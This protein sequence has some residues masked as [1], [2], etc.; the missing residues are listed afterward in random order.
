MAGLKD[1]GSRKTAR[2]QLWLSVSGVHLAWIQT[3]PYLYFDPESCTAAHRQNQ[4]GGGVAIDTGFPSARN[5]GRVPEPVAE[6]AARSGTQVHFMI[7]TTSMRSL[8]VR[9]M[10]HWDTGVQ[11][12]SA[13]PRSQACHDGAVSS[14]S[15]ANRPPRRTRTHARNSNNNNNNDDDYRLF[16]GDEESSSPDAGTR[17]TN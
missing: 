6:S 3:Y 15:H 7:S 5:R 1:D 14:D 10:A 9:A 8:R 12:K 16:D 17:P 2:L 13:L 4:C 11:W